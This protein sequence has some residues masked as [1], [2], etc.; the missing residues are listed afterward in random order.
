[1][2]IGVGQSLPA[3]ALPTVD[4]NEFIPPSAQGALIKTMGLL[5]NHR[6]YQGAT[7]LGVPGVEAGAEV[8]LVHLPS[9]LGPSLQS[10]G[11]GSGSLGIGSLPSLKLHLHKSMGR[12]ADIGLSGILYRGN[13]VIGG[14][15][16][17][18][19][20]EPEEGLQWAFRFGYND[21]S[22]NLSNL[23]MSSIPIGGFAEGTM[24][25][26]GY[27]L[28]PQLVVSKRLDFAEPYMGLGLEY[29]KGQIDLP[30]TILLDNSTETYSTAS[31]TAYQ[32][33]LFGG[34]IF[35][36]PN[37]GLRIGIELAY[38]NQGMHTLGIML[39]I[40]F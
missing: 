10:A 21:F 16:K 11:M 3:W 14:H 32:A 4:V 36:P 15:L 26:N 9:D 1:M 7:S 23:G 31:Q 8:T 25:L 35:R 29:N 6:P 40:G 18:L 13:T 19:L 17:I 24:I 28:T 22:I 12:S 27:T 30:I 38:S 34:I 37:T 39:G 5:F 2:L 20:Y 33:A